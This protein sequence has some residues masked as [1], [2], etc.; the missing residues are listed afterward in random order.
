MKILVTGAAGFIGFHL[1]QRLLEKGHQVLGYDGMTK[2][3]DVSLKEK[4]LA[5]LKRWSKFRFVA[6]MLEE[7]SALDEAVDGF[8]PEVIIHLAAQAGVRYSL[9]A[10]E[11]YISSNLLGSFNVLELAKKIRPR[12]LLIASTSSVYG[13]N[14]KM[15]FVEADRT[16]FPVSLYAATKKA[17][18]EMSHSYAHLFNIPTT[19]FRFFTVYGAWGRPDMALYKFVDAIEQGHA[20]EVYGMGQMQRDSTAVGDL[21]EAISRLID[22]VPDS[23]KPAHGVQDSLSP[24]APWRVVNIAGGTP[25][26]LLKF[27]AAIES[28]LGKVAI[29]NMLPMQA[30]DVV[31]TFADAGLLKALTGYAPSTPIETC[32]DEFVVWYRKYKSE[33]AFES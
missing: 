9:E 6:A 3:Y 32:V 20:I 25:T 1:S 18:E 29:K 22:A 4:R 17:C 33:I 23:S 2:Y 7:K 11:A 26:P 15:P 5:I 13:G 21:V 19:C 30:G 10:P 24:V 28:A 14:E 27:I 12:H 31:S 16:D 8:E